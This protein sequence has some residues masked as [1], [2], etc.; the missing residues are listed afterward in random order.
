MFEDA[1]SQQ[2]GRRSIRPPMVFYR[3]QDLLLVSKLDSFRCSCSPSCPSLRTVVDSLLWHDRWDLASPSLPRNGAILISSSPDQ[4]VIRLRSSRISCSLSTPT[5][6][7]RGETVYGTLPS[8][9]LGKN[10]LLLQRLVTLRTLFRSHLVSLF[11]LERAN[12]LSLIRVDAHRMSKIMELRS[13][14]LT[15]V[16]AF[17]LRPAIYEIETDSRVLTRQASTRLRSTS[18]HTP[19][20]FRSSN[21]TPHT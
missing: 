7:V 10:N 8:R 9:T 18:D 11:R 4:A 20:L 2:E 5:F 17:S 13:R 15:G 21:D 16:S 6:A 1:H 3:N 19:I 12:E 14:M